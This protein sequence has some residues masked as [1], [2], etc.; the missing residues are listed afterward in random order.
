MSPDLGVDSMVWRQDLMRVAVLDLDHLPVK[1]VFVD[2]LRRDPRKEVSFAIPL[3]NLVSR[4][5]IGVAQPSAPSQTLGFGVHATEDPSVHRVHDEP[6]RLH[7]AGLPVAGARAAEGEHIAARQQD[8]IDQLPE[9][10]VALDAGG[11][12]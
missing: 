1:V 8:V 5:Q 6:G 4:Q 7:G 11:I 9:L 10:G 12:P 2:V 3:Q